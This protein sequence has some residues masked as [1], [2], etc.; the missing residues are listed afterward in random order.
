MTTVIDD[1]D[2]GK[3]HIR[4][5]QWSKRVS[6]RVHVDGSV[7]VTAPPKTP[8]GHLR[9]IVHRERASIL[10]MLADTPAHHV[11]VDGERVGQAHRIVM[12]RSDTVTTTHVVVREQNIVCTVPTQSTPKDA[13]VQREI[14]SVVIDALRKEA[15]AY[16][17]RRLRVLADRHDY[18][19]QR[20][21][22]THA[23][24]R[25]GSCSS[26]GT[27][28]LNIALMK[29]SLELIDY[30]LL[31]ELC[32]TVEMN[33]SKSFWQRVAACDPDYTLHRKQ[34]KQHSPIV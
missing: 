14:R 9:R 1:D 25:W 7:I 11:Y 28:S 3:V 33:H 8:V 5:H 34:L 23:S 18:T 15:R 4:R 31:H 13:S 6:I 20:I 30:V 26:T 32:H 21:R 24:S 29:L 12:Q 2:I 10:Q 19:Y 22:F 16:L 27:I 17:T